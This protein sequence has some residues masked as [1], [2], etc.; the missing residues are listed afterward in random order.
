M[1]NIVRSADQVQI[2]R[3][4]GAE[5]IVN[6]AEPSFIG[7]LF[8]ALEETGA[9][10]AFDAVGGGKLAVQILSGME[11]VASASAK[12]YSGYGS[13]V[14]KQVYIYGA[15]DT[16]PT[17]LTRSFGMA[18]GIGG[19]LLFNF[20]VKAGPETVARLKA[21]VAAEI[22]TTFASHYTR[23]ISLLEALDPDVIA[24]YSRRATGEKFLINPNLAAE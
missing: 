3:D 1:V 15:L 22:K 13:S 2:L 4:L 16:G 19:W 7:D 5:H 11:A 23:T 8:A 9:T 20:L 21:R 24:A 10:L 17:E 18:W 12:S 14:H 6:S